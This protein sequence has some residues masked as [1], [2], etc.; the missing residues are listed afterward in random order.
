MYEELTGKFLSVQTVLRDDSH[1]EYAQ[2]FPQFDFSSIDFEQQVTKLLHTYLNPQVTWEAVPKGILTGDSDDA[3]VV[4]ATDANQIYYLK[5]TSSLHVQLGMLFA[6]SYFHDYPHPFCKAA[7][8]VSHGT[9]TLKNCT[10]SYFML[11]EK[12]E[13]ED[14]AAAFENN[15]I[16]VIYSYA[17][18]AAKVLAYN[19]SNH[20]SKSTTLDK[21]LY[22]SRTSNLLIEDLYKL[23]GKVASD[24]P[25]ISGCQNIIPFLLEKEREYLISPQVHSLSVSPLKI[26]NL[27]YSMEN[28]MISLFDTTGFFKYCAPSQL[29]RWAPETEFTTFINNIEFLGCFWKLDPSNIQKIEDRFLQTYYQNIRRPIMTREG[30]NLFMTQRYLVSVKNFISLSSS[31]NDFEEK[32]LKML[33]DFSH[34]SKRGNL[35]VSKL[36][37]G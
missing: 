6:Y 32:A 5:F 8:I 2:S 1:T 14:I 22:G 34:F 28:R 24:S 15:E 23:R 31:D 36:L 12:A 7:K 29:P 18:T 37:G 21:L 17:E 9:I 13:G 20:V 25:L 27:N 11:L 3:I 26:W 35:K 19:H 10:S 16:E 30:L 4:R 33:F